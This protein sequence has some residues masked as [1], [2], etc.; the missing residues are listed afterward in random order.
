VSDKKR[1]QPWEDVAFNK[2]EQFRLK[3]I[4]VIREA[5]H[6]FKKKGYHNT[7]LEDIAGALG[8]TKGA[9]YYYI[10]SK[11]EV[12]FESHLLAI[13][14]AKNAADYAMAQSDDPRQIIASMICKYFELSTSDKGVSAV[15]TEFE[16]LDPAMLEV[17]AAKR[18]EVSKWFQDIVARGIAE[19]SLHALDPGLATIFAFGSVNWMA[20]WYDPGGPFS[21]QEVGEAFAR[22][23]LK[24]LDAV[25]GEGSMREPLRLPQ[26]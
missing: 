18:A 16:A 25:P 14:I 4:A 6:A 21:S 5:A 12:L 20:H 26:V 8:V 9:L 22:F 15:L 10:K 17:I 24:G 3:R 11:K 19:G 1:H 23:I 13:E 2:D 7:S